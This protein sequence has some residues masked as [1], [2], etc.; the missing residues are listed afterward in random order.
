LWKVDDEATGEL[1]KHFYANML[2]KGMR[3]ADALR[4]AQNT[5]RQDPNWQAPHFWA[6]FTLQGEF[7]DPIRVP[8]PRTAS[9]FVQK[10]VG[11]GLLM[12]L[13]AGIGWGYWRRRGPQTVN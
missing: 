8:A 5:L 3:P 10:T 13:L 11:A 1:M 2:K 9:P 6:G 7:K 4:A 12:A